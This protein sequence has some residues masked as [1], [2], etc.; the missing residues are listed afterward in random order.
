[1]GRDFLDSRPIKSVDELWTTWA[2]SCHQ[3][4]CSDR[5]ETLADLSRPRDASGSIPRCTL[6]ATRWQGERFPRTLWSVTDTAGLKLRA[7]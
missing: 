4:D 3:A 2:S 5:G 6:S 1:M 7:H